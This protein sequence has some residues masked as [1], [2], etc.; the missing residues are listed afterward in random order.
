MSPDTRALEDRAIGCLLGAAV[1]DAAGGTLEFRPPP[2]L[3]RVD[4]AMTMP[5][6]GAL[7]LAPGQVTDD[8][9]LALCLA[10]A[11]A[12]SDAFDIETVARAYARWIDSSPFDIGRTTWQ[13]LGSFRDA[14]WSGVCE[15]DGYASCMKQAAELKCSGS[16]ANGSLMR[17]APLGIWGYNLQDDALARLAIEDS[18]LSH[19]N[20]SCCQAVAC[21]VI[22]ISSLLD[23]P[24]DRSRAF[25]RAV[26]WAET[27]ANEEVR[28]WLRDAREN[29]SVD[30]LSQIGFVRIAFTNAF[31]HLL[32]ESSYEETIRRTLL[33]GGDTDT[34][35]CIAGG[36]IG[37][38]CGA[39]AIPETMKAPVLECDTG[40][41][42]PRPDFLHPRRAPELARRLLRRGAGS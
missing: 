17:S 33:R 3:G 4:H 41:G 6:G 24:D 11:L 32:M 16:K 40:R 8:T 20:P 38:A 15:R 23:R 2:T 22:A 42:R 35:A 31:Q 18:S 36:L 26:S 12:N 13:S 34:N 27:H 14:D 1:G 9:E 7:R 39:E 10:D 5:G 37:V 28:V 29:A 19:P 21:Y 30:F 25:E